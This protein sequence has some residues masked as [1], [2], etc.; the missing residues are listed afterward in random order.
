VPQQASV[1]LTSHTLDSSQVFTSSATDLSSFYA[2]TWAL[3]LCLSYT[4]SYFLLFLN[5]RLDFSG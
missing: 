5:L 4:I 1:T 2:Q 3:Q